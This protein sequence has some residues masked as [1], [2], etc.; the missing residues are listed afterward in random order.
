MGIRV[1]KLVGYGLTDVKTRKHRIADDRFNPDGFATARD[2]SE[3]DFDARWSEEGYKQFLRRLDLVGYDKL[4]RDNE[5]NNNTPWSIYRAFIHQ[6]EFG[7]PNVAVIIPP[8]LL[9][10]WFRYDDIVD[11]VEETAAHEQMSR[12]VEISGGIYPY[13]ARVDAATRCVYTSEVDVLVLGDQDPEAFNRL[14]PE[15]PPGVRWLASYL[16]LF[17][18]PATVDELRPLLYVYWS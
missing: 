2:I 14:R 8:S 10:S 13:T 7:L 11:W 12:V 15:I 1:H 16:E 9:K 18:D 4:V 3:E 6:G 5:L 17:R